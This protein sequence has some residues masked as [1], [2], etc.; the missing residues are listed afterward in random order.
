MKLASKVL[1]ALTLFVSSFAI[2]S[3]IADLA[4][5]DQT[6]RDK[7][8][9]VLLRT[10]K[11][12]PK[13]KWTPTIDKIKQGQ[14][15]KDIRELLLQFKVTEEGSR[16]GGG[17]HSQVFRLDDDWILCCHFR[18]DGDKLIDK[19]LIR[20][21]RVVRVPLPDNYTGRWVI[22]YVNG[23]KVEESTYKNGRLFGESIVYHPNGAKRFVQNFT[24][25]GLD[26]DDTGYYP[27]GSVEYRSHFK[28]GKEVG[29][30]TWYDEAGKI[31]STKD[32]PNP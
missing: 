3:P 21:P 8:A 10:Y 15:E 7:S 17:S 4:S 19:L 30:S 26:G 14:T 28:E 12:S 24:E 20:Y 32:H 22:Y 31:T 6:V 27:S 25:K 1:L 11:D 9:A 29:T 16:A 13:S 2:A 5:P 23:I 18:T